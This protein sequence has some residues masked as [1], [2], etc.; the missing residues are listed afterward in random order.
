MGYV[1]GN[2][3]TYFTGCD[4]QSSFTQ[5]DLGGRR[6]G[7]RRGDCIELARALASNFEKVVVT[8]N[9]EVF[10]SYYFLI[11]AQ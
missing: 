2:R 10:A 3:Q 6:R 4:I 1:I 8:Q 7:I 9:V 11:T 5:L